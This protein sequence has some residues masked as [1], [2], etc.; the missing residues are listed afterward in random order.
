MILTLRIKCVCILSSQYIT[1][2]A[3]CDILQF[4]IY[5]KFK[6]YIH[7]IFIFNIMYLNVRGLSARS[8]H[9]TRIDMTHTLR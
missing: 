6:I 9:V 8:K 1:N 2:F 4:V 3:I 5:H 7:I